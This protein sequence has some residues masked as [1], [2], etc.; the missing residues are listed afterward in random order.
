MSLGQAYIAS[1]LGDVD[2]NLG[3]HRRG[4]Q[5]RAGQRDALGQYAER[6]GGS[7]ALH[8]LDP[9]QRDAR[10]RAARDGELLDIPDPAWPADASLDQIA[11]HEWPRYSPQDAPPL[12]FPAM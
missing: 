8:R 9:A 11:A 2:N 3:A 5:W 4:L 12:I 1:L 6:V 7:V 10:L